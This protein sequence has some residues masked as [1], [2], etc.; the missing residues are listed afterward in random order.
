[1]SKISSDF[2]DTNITVE[3]EGREAYDI[4]RSLTQAYS[5]AGERN[6]HKVIIINGWER[7]ITKGPAKGLHADNFDFGI[8]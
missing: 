5:L 8:I 6:V 4:H 2:G 7:Q 1:M 3:T